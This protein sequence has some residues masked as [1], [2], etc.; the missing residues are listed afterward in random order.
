MADC[1]FGHEQPGVFNFRA[2]RIIAALAA[3]AAVA[4]DN[5]RLRHANE[6][7]I[8]ARKRAEADLQQLNSSLERRAEERAQELAVSL[9][10][11]EDTERRF[12][13][14]VQ[15]VTDYA[16]YMLD[17]DGRVINWNPGAERIKGYAR[18][19]IIGRHFSTFYTPE[20]LSRD[21]PATACARRWRL[22]STKPKAGGSA[23]TEQDFGR[24]LS[25][26]PSSEAMANILVSQR[27][28][29]T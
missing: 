15:G 24:A 5:V 7:E 22:A 6:Q 13:H 20:D 21:V 14:L 28:R 19:E 17:V 25:S 9:T 11:L 2:E 16:I 23:K 27:S 3:Q 10:K 4:I 26:T 8:T 18:S 12:Q 1:F 29:G